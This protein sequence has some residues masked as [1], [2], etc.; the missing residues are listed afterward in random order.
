MQRN[1]A[2][3]LLRNTERDVVDSSDL[4]WECVRNA[5]LHAGADS[6]FCEGGGGPSRSLPASFF[7]LSP[8]PS[9]RR[10]SRPTFSTHF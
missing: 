1:R 5:G 2:S 10:R 3:D 4:D 8:S 6:G 9:V 7:S